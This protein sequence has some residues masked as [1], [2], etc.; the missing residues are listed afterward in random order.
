MMMMMMMMVSQTSLMQS[1]D[2]ER[3]GSFSYSPP[4]FSCCSVSERAEAPPSTCSN[5]LCAG[6]TLLRGVFL[7]ILREEEE[8]EE[9]RA[10]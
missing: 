2:F 7:P 5:S 9:E 10:S 1:R 4:L 8:E 6:Q 3:V